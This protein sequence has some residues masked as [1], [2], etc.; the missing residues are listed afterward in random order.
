MKPLPPLPRTID[1]AHS[2]SKSEA[3]DIFLM[4]ACRFFIG[5]SSGPAYVPPLFGIPCVLTNWAPTGSRPFNQRDLYIPKLY[6]SGDPPTLWKFDMFL[7]PPVGYAA[8]YKPPDTL[9]LAPVFN[10]PEELREVVVEM[11]DRL[12]GRLRY[13]QEDEAL[14]TTFD[15]VALASRC[16]GNARIGRDFL[17]RHADLLSALKTG[18]P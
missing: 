16:I 6:R 11:L 3:M 17:R 7:A 14:Q 4:G 8:T 1:Y 15:A 9:D 10:S 2:A 12:D 5:T 18:H 13:T